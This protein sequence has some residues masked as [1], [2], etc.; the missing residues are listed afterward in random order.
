MSPEIFTTR[1]TYLGKNLYGCRVVFIADGSL[2][3]E[4]R[5]S[6]REIGNA[7]YDILRTADKMGYCSPMASATRKRGKGRTTQ[8]KYIWGKS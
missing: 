6:K 4:L 2:F 8:S 3:A 1:V 5:V 7:I